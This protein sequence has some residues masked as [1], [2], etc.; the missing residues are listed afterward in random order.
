MKIQLILLFFTHSAL[1][2]L[3]ELL[4]CIQPIGQLKTYIDSMSKNQEKIRSLSKNAHE[5]LGFV[6]ERERV[7]LRALSTSGEDLENS[8]ASARI[9]EKRPPMLQMS[10]EYITDYIIRNESTEFKT[11]LSLIHD[12]TALKH[13]E[14]ILAENIIPRI[15]A[16][17]ANMKERLEGLKFQASEVLNH[18]E[19]QAA[20]MLRE[21]E[22]SQSNLTK[23]LMEKNGQREEL[24]ELIVQNTKIFEQI[25]AGPVLPALGRKTPLEY[26]RN[27]EWRAA[28]KETLGGPPA[29]V[30]SRIRGIIRDMPTEKQAQVLTY[31]K[32]KLIKTHELELAALS[33]KIAQNREEIDTLRAQQTACLRVYSGIILD[34]TWFAQIQL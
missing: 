19:A 34:Q 10:E 21:Y 4:D 32:N 15:D 18:A 30:A 6:F 16:K 20:I 28:I 14:K 5:C 2:S 3:K 7:L 11:M 9:S 8:S 1:G 31:V 24:S 26:S 12:P 29:V 23:F 17:L 22:N 27:S 25:E 13:I 33:E